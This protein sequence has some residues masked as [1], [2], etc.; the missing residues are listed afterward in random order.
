[1]NSTVQKYFCDC[2]ISYGWEKSL[3]N[4]S[5]LFKSIQWLASWIF[6]NSTGNTESTNGLS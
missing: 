1:L 6:S 3:K 2:S 5:K 4:N